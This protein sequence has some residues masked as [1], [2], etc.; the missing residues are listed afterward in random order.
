ME[1]NPISAVEQAVFAFLDGEKN[2]ARSL[3]KSLS[4]DELTFGLSNFSGPR[5]F[6][7]WKDIISDENVV[8]FLKSDSI[9]ARSFASQFILESPQYK[10]IKGKYNLGSR[11]LI[12]SPEVGEVLLFLDPEFTQNE[13]ND[14]SSVRDGL[15]ELG[16]SLD[17]F[18]DVTISCSGLKKFQI[19]LRKSEAER[20]RE[21]K[22]ER[23]FA[24]KVVKSSL[25][26]GLIIGGLALGM[27]SA[28]ADNSDQYERA[29]G[30]AIE[31]AMIQSGAKDMLDKA[32]QKAEDAT[33]KFAKDT[34]T[35]PI[36]A[37]AVLGAQTV[38]DKKLTI[39]SKNPLLKNSTY[40]FTVAQNKEVSLELRGENPLLKDSTYA[41][42]AT[43]HSV[44]VGV[45]VSF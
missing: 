33:M 37:L 34:G 1:R 28:F 7:L 14:L 27:E 31:A 30:A 2:E 41:I 19:A 36:A 17:R 32:K 24:S 18:V 25:V 38:R 11:E 35:E 6:E 23:S 13:E 29:K 26:V 8:A 42:N 45:S 4:R 16:E 3:A 5:E 15:S 12:V 22:I 20:V 44:E 10:S 21:E 39:K 9:E 40:K 43:P